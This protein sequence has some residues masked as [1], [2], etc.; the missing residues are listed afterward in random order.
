MRRCS[1]SCQLPRQRRAHSVLAKAAGGDLPLAVSITVHA[2]DLFVK[3]LRTR[4]PFRYGIATMT[5]VPHLV[6]RLTIETGGRIQ[7]GCSADHLPPKWFTKDPDSAY[8]DDLAEMVG[9]IR[10]ACDTASALPATGSVFALWRELYAAQSAWAAAGN[11]PPLLAGFG[12]SLVERALIDAFCR[13]HGKSFAHAVRENALGFDAGALHGELAGVAP[14]DFLPP[15]PLRSIAVRHTVG[16]ADPLT[17]DGIE[18]GERVRDGLPQSLEAVI[19]D[20]GVT[21][22][23]IKLSGEINRDLTW[24]R[25][26]AKVL[27]AGVPDAAFTLDGNEN[28]RAVAPFRALWDEMLGDPRIA[29]L[30]RGLIFVEQPLHRDVALS[31]ETAT[32]LLAWRG[33]PPI[34]IDESD[35]EFSSLPT[36]LASGYAGTSHKNCKGVFK[37]LASAALI[38][39]RRHADPSVPLHLSA[40]DLSNVGPIALP[41]DLA[42]L[43]TLGIPHAERNG[44]HYFAGLSQ[45]SPAI[46]SAA[47]IAHADLYE[48]HADG[49]PIVRIRAG[50][51]ETGSVVDAPFGVAFEPDLAGFTP[52]DEWRPGSLDEAL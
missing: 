51:M 20:Y 34:I 11:T 7:H 32:Q 43:A 3:N 37:G 5:R 50:R 33:R 18:S 21:H 16:L 38:A 8:R 31:E 41:Q 28:Y 12:T 6:V 39:H 13:V 1:G 22:F 26:I 14:A 47:Q 42:V 24:L 2:A 44:H 27:A 49:F 48:P 40:E 10:H 30:L 17:E 45:F 52:L 23:K 15:A 35:A 29:I 9:V 46:Q 19:R 25:G 36:A 4:L